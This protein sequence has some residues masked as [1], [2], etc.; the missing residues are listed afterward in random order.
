MALKYL[1]EEFNF[2]RKTKL[3]Y[4]NDLSYNNQDTRVTS[5]SGLKICW[6]EGWGRE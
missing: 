4:L 5:R 3:F 1:A 6:S 2:G